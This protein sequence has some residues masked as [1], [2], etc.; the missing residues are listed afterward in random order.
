M[1][2]CPAKRRAGQSELKS[3]QSRGGK[4]WHYHF[5]FLPNTFYLCLFAILCSTTKLLTLDFFSLLFSLNHHH[6]GLSSFIN[7][8]V[9]HSFPIIPFSLPV[10]CKLLPLWQDLFFLISHCHFRVPEKTT[11]TVTS[12]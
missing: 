6:T 10:S 4:G 11:R 3:S 7:I 5:L 1:S 8:H 9:C 2:R 12:Q